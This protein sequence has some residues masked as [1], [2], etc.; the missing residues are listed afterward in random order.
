MTQFKSFI[1]SKFVGGGGG[2]RV[3]GREGVERLFFFN[4]SDFPSDIMEAGWPSG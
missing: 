4:A 2:G 3:G 1:T